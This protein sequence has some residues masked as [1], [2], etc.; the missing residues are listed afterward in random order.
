M[1]EFSSKFKR[2]GYRRLH[3]MLRRS[4]FNV[5]HKRAYRLYKDAGL[6][7]KRKSKKRRYEKRGTLERNIFEQ[8]YRWSMDFVSDVTRTG[9]RFRVF[10]LID[11]V[12]RECLA[13]EIDSSI[14][15]QRVT[16]YLNKVALFKGLPK[17]ILT[18]NGPEFTS[19]ALNTWAYDKNVEHIFY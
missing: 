19:K 17:K 10:T 4:G 18:D 13:L 5:N 3:I 2:Y 15:G 11:E 8:N 1:I 12:T 6:E 14:T 7:L 9:K 16:N